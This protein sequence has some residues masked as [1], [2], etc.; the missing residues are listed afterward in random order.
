MKQLMLKLKYLDYE[1]KAESYK[2]FK[3][4]AIVSIANSKEY[5]KIDEI[6]EYSY[7]NLHYNIKWNFCLSDEDLQKF[8]EQKNLFIQSEIETQTVQSYSFNYVLRFLCNV[9]NRKML[10][11]VIFL[12]GNKII[13]KAGKDYLVF[14]NLEELNNHVYDNF[15]FIIEQDTIDNFISEIM[16]NNF[17]DEQK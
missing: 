15:N 8:M 14:N 1:L 17:V 7:E 4:E 11:F 3:F 9:Y 6:S 13:F 2:H 16:L 5:N 12:S 10:L